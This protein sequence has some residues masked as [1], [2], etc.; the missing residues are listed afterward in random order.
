MQSCSTSYPV[1]DAIPEGLSVDSPYRHITHENDSTVLQL[2]Y[3][4]DGGDYII[5]EL[6]AIHDGDDDF[7]LS[8]KDI[9]QHPDHMMPGRSVTALN[10]V[11]FMDYLENLNESERYQK[12]ADNIG[13][14]ILGGLAVLA[15]ATSSEATA[16][17]AALVG[18]D[19][20]LSAVENN[21]WRNDR[22][23]SLEDEIAYF[24]ETV[25]YEERV[26]PGDTII[27]DVLFRSTEVPVAPI[28]IDVNWGG[29]SYEFPYTVIE[30]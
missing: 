28:V 5:Y 17:G 2:T 24:T 3:I 29:N 4:A 13:L 16:V 21:A 6:F 9:V 20:A 8:Y 10:P 15:Y 11:T 30:R 7:T 12:K 14:A 1:Y 22:I 26:Y 18:A 19:Y 27:C 25:L 23:R